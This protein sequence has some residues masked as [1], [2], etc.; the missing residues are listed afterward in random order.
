[1]KFQN[2]LKALAV[3]MIFGGIGIIWLGLNMMKS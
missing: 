2:I 1:M 3:S